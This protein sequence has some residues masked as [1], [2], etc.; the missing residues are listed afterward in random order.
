[1]VICIM[2]AQVGEGS[3]FM[4]PSLDLWHSTLRPGKHGDVCHFSS[5]PYRDHQALMAKSHF[6]TRKSSCLEAG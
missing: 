5:V 4:L 1:M 2:A 3:E 6:L